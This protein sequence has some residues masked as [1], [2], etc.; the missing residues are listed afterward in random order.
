[1]KQNWS[2]YGYRRPQTHSDVLDWTVVVPLDF[3]RLIF[4]RMKNGKKKKK[5]E[6]VT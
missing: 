3:L 5:S 4:L 1:M 6:G 2:R